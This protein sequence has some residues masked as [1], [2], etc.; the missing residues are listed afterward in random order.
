MVSVY[1]PGR[2]SGVPLP[3]PPP[4]PLRAHPHPVKQVFK[5]LEFLGWYTTGG[6]P[7]PSDIHVHK[8]VSGAGGMEECV[9]VCAPH[10]DA[11]SSVPQVCEIIESPLFLKLNPMTKHTDV[12]G[13]EV[14]RSPG[15]WGAPRIPLPPP[16]VGLGPQKYIFFSFPPSCLSVSLSLSLTSSMGR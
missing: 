10:P 4:S 7:D 8:Q 1:C 14:G 15:T 12:S 11:A 6:P 3:C 13:G 9:C 5:E 16:S 2:V